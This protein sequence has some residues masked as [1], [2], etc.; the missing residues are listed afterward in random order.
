MPSN[1]CAS[2]ISRCPRRYEEG[3]PLIGL[4]GEIF[5]RLNTFS[6]D[7]SARRI[8]QLGGECWLS[9]VSEWVWYTNWSRET[10]C[11]RDHG[12][13]TAAF[14][15][16]KLKSHVQHRYEQALMGPVRRDFEG[17][18]EPDDIRE[19]LRESEPYLPATGALGEMTL[20]AGKA[21]YLYR[22]GAD[23]I[24]DISP[25]TCMNGI[26]SEAVYPAI[27]ADHDDLPIR[28]LYFDKLNTNI[29]RDLE[30]FLDLARAYQR[31]KKTP[32]RL[33]V[34]L[35]LVRILV[36]GAVSW[37]DMARLEHFMNPTDTDV[38]QERVHARTTPTTVSLHQVCLE[39][40]ASATVPPSTS[41]QQRSGVLHRPF[42]EIHRDAV[43]PE[44]AKTA[45]EEFKVSLR[46][47]APVQKGVKGLPWAGQWHCTRCDAVVPG[48]VCYDESADAIYLELDCP[49]CGKWQEHHHDVLFVRKRQPAHSRQPET[50]YSGTPIRPIVT[51][52]PK[53]VETLCPECSC[54]LLGRYYEKDGA[55]W[56][57][58]TCPEHG[59]CRDKISSDPGLYLRATR[60]G[61]QDERGVHNPHVRCAEACP[62]DC[63]LC[64]QHLSTTCLAQIDMT[65]RCNLTCPV[66]FASA[67]QSRSVSEPTYDMVVE[68]M[69]SLRNLHPYPATALQFTGG[70]PTLHPEFFKLTRKAREMGFS[71]IQ[72]ATN[73]ITLA[74]RTFA[75]RAAEAGLHT[76][77]LQF[78]GLDDALYRKLRAEPLLEKKLKTIE[79]C[80]EFGMKICLVPTIV[81]GT[82]RDQ[83]PKIFNFAAQNA[84]VISGISYQ[85]VTFTGRISR[86]ELENKRY[87][88]GD[89]AHD[90]A[91]VSGADI[92]RDFQPLNTVAPLSRMLQTLDGKPKIRPSCHSDCAF[93]SYFFVTPDRQVIPIPKL[94][95]YL[96]L[97]NGF[98]EFAARVERTRPDQRAT[99]KDKLDLMFLFMRT[100]RWSARD[101]RVTP[102]TFIK[103][104]RGM[105]DKGH[106]RG[107]TGQKTYRTLMAAG[108][109][110]MDRYNFDTERVKRCVILYSTVDGIYPFCTI[111]G[112]PTFRP[113]IEAMY[114]Q[115]ADQWQSQN[116]DVPLRPSSDP[117]AALPYQR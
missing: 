109:H 73:G 2:A 10:D 41:D 3:R 72:I 107:S 17:Y 100:Y 69:Q 39:H 37:P 47:Y 15:K 117:G 58:K 22:K 110:F 103:A 70:E 13:F 36:T 53:T 74:D 44:D 28:S 111:N 12:R 34:L 14:L 18:E 79:N 86:H 54:L 89:L 52:L 27:S 46:R 56:I 29:D 78:D 42:D 62:T 115:N 43:T 49:T 112:G 45:L 81:N 6:N 65:N 97:M 76:L 7:D 95:D 64:N 9:D 19:V 91:A 104:L 98:N 99:W 116:P 26:V 31:R 25:F 11:I 50:T 4:V 88:L 21:I 93:G 16:L 96:R 90:I 35:S 67:N 68:M 23:G 59:Y 1:G 55:V 51:A 60:A 113:F 82:N 92:E 20:S 114:A 85:P 71:H 101:F 5:C 94:F 8:E 32:P 33:P 66:C 105:T 108:M 77:Y 84:D 63:G 24:I 57:E 30:I 80:R 83:V 38:S 75:E 61:F 40:V 87:T 102:F 106:G 48:S